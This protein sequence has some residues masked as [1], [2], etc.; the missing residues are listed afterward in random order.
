M[1]SYSSE[2]ISFIDEPIKDKLLRLLRSRS[3]DVFIETITFIEERIDDSFFNNNLD[4][5]NFIKF[6]EDENSKFDDNE[7]KNI[8]E[9]A[10]YNQAVNPHNILPFINEMASTI[11]NLKI[12]NGFISQDHEIP[13]EGRQGVLKYYENCQYTTEMIEFI[14]RHRIVS[15][16]GGNG[17]NRFLFTIVNGEIITEPKKDFREIYSS[18]VKDI[19]KKIG[20]IDDSNLEKYLPEFCDENQAKEIV[21]ILHRLA[22]NGNLRDLDSTNKDLLR[23]YFRT[24]PNI[25]YSRFNDF[26]LSDKVN[27]HKDKSRLNIDN[28]KLIFDDG[29]YFKF[30][31]NKILFDNKLD[32]NIDFNDFFNKINKSNFNKFL[33]FVS[34][35]LRFNNEVKT[36]LGMMLLVDIDQFNILINQISIDL[37]KPNYSKSNL[38]SK[39]INFCDQYSKINNI[40]QSQVDEPRIRN[41]DFS[42]RSRFSDLINNLLETNIDFS[43]SLI[44]YSNSQNIYN[45]LSKF[46]ADQFSNPQNQ[47]YKNNFIK[48]FTKLSLSSQSGSEVS[49]IIQMICA[50]D[51]SASAIKSEKGISLAIFHLQLIN[52]EITSS[53][54]SS[55]QSQAHDQDSSAGVMG[56][57]RELLMQRRGLVENNQSIQLTPSHQL[58][59]EMIK[60]DKNA[61]HFSNLAGSDADQIMKY[62]FLGKGDQDLKYCL[63]EENF[64]KLK[65]VIENNPLRAI[66]N[67]NSSTEFEFSS[68]ATSNGSHIGSRLDDSG[69]TIGIHNTNNKIKLGIRIADG[70][71]LS[72]IFDENQNLIIDSI[73]IPDIV[74]LGKISNDS[75]LK[76]L[77]PSQYYDSENQYSLRRIDGQWWIGV[78]LE[79]PDSTIEFKGA[80]KADF[81]LF[82]QNEFK[83][84]SETITEIK[85]TQ[86]QIVNP[87]DFDIISESSSIASD[88]IPFRTDSSSNA[89]DPIPFQT[90]SSSS[91]SDSIP[92][93]TVS[94]SNISDPILFQADSFPSASN[95]AKQNQGDNDSID[96]KQCCLGLFG[97]CLARK[98]ISLNPNINF[99]GFLNQSRRRWNKVRENFRKNILRR[100]E[101]IIYHKLAKNDFSTITYDDKGHPIIWRKLGEKN[102]SQILVR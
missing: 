34:F 31:I 13:I 65:T 70:V 61:C 97:R 8:Y 27:F 88:P 20:I 30:K 3:E 102:D 16:H 51:N 60:E 6:L 76:A 52:S 36:K 90:D 67:L 24:L 11:P 2:E 87:G 62:L 40:K 79:K 19:F 17:N 47:H 46:S 89:S 101:P 26:I 98:N 73:E 43:N 55:N 28:F 14:N 50:L 12:L 63:G 7:I 25:D 54:A 57:R 23:N 69:F 91:A 44:T 64:V 86:R 93:Q 83:K 5:N 75:I 95:S 68:I 48:F 39:I 94:S 33:D 56:L 80:V 9:F 59:L 53:L 10:L 1:K 78:F 4:I 29:Y 58:F 82:L 18:V 92:F 32:L 100:D 45:L 66:P 74:E 84:I 72:G 49:N 99:S 22:R 77:I 15:S 38:T 42:Y 21:I 81:G 35:P 37:N 85:E 41:D 71:I 96:S